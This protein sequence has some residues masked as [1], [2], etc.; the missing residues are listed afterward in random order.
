MEYIYSNQVDIDPFHENLSEDDVQ[1]IF[2]KVTGVRNKEKFLTKEKEEQKRDI[3]MLHHFGM[4]LRQISVVTGV[5]K[6]NIAR[7]LS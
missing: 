2:R 3:R 4:S 5:P 1:R 6:S 7:W